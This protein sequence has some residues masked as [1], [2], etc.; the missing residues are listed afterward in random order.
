LV[1]SGLAVLS[2]LLGSLPFGLF[3]GLLRGVDL[4]KHGSGNVGAT[5]VVRVLGKPLGFAVFA[6]DFLKGLVPALFFPALAIDAGSPWS[7]DA[8]ALCFGALAVVGHV[9]P[10]WLKF[11]GGKGVATSAGL[12]FGVAWSATLVS[13][14]IW[15]LVLKGSRYVSLASLASAIAFPFVFVAIEG[16]GAAFGP[17]RIVTVALAVLALTI[18]YTHR[19]NIGRLLRGE[20][21]RAGAVRTGDKRT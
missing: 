12:C 18:V 2:Y 5:N 4:R 21:L 7:R 19:S 8:L 14:A 6:L 3:A 15:F 10:V 1:T 13:F 20:E 11:K 9:F 16:T 17:R